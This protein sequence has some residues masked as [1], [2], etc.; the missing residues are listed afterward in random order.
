M[1]VNPLYC[2]LSAW[3]GLEGYC[4]WDNKILENRKKWCSGECL[5]EWRTQHRYFLARQALL[6]RS[7]RKCHCVRLP[8]EQRHLY[9]HDCGS[10]EVLILLRGGQMTCDHIIPRFGDKARFSCKHHSTNL[11]LLC[12]FCH[13]RKTKEDEN[14]LGL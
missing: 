4:R 6:K 14:L 2:S 10:C 12:S 9:C 8:N 11:Q 13:V 5:L 7:R 3:N 1:S